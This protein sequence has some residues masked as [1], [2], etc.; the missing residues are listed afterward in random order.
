MWKRVLNTD[1]FVNTSTN[2]EEEITSVNLL[3]D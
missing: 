3:G 2:K 1:A